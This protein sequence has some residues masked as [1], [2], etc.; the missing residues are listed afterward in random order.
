M[1]QTNVPSF[2]EML[3]AAQHSAVHLEMRDAYGIESEDGTF[4]A[5]REGTWTVASDREAR[6]AWFDLV[7]AAVSRG[8]VMRRARIVSEPATAYIRFEYEAPG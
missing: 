2:A 5:W 4:R 6:R 8:V 1:P 3:E 7:R